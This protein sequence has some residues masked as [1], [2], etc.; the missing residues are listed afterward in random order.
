MKVEQRRV[1]RGHDQCS[2]SSECVRSVDLV[3]RE[4]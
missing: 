4:R 3:S 1:Q 2:V